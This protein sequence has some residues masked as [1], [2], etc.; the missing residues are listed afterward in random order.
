MAVP[1]PTWREKGGQGR[2][3]EGRRRGGSKGRARGGNIIIASCMCIDFAALPRFSLRAARGEKTREGK[4]LLLGSFRLLDFPLRKYRVCYDFIMLRVD[5]LAS[6][7]ACLGV[8]D[9]ERENEEDVRRGRNII[10][11]SRINYTG[12][13]NEKKKE[14]NAK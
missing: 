9:A 10:V 7:P 1:G 5:V 3:G 12:G 14:G 11:R 4:D 2:A 8:S 6:R 13:I